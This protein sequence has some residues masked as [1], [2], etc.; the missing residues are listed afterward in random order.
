MASEGKSEQELAW[1][2]NLIFQ[3]K[4]DDGVEN[5]TELKLGYLWCFAVQPLNS[6]ELPLVRKNF[7][8]DGLLADIGI[9]V[10]LPILSS[11]P[12]TGH[13]VLTCTGI[14]PVA[15]GVVE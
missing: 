7:M 2:L 8:V 11:P 1:V 14:A 4:N 13:P 10:V 12:A 15:L 5:F 6:V 9:G 3:Y